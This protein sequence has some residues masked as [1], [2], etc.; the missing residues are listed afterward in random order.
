MTT[1]LKWL[2]K[3][4]LVCPSC[5]HGSSKIIDRKK[6]V[7]TLRRCDNCRLL[8]RTPTIT[9]EENHILYQE[10][11]QSDFTTDMPS[12]EE[13][14]SLKKAIFKDTVKDYSSRINVLEALSC[15]KGER[16][17]DFGCSWGY[18]SWQFSKAGYVVKAFEIS[19]P[20][21][22]YAKQY[23]GVEA[24]SSL[25]ELTGP[26]DIFFSSHVLGHVPNVRETI[27]DGWRKLRPG[28]LFV[29]FT[30]NSSNAYRMKHPN[31]WHD[32]WS[33]FLPNLLDEIYYN[34]VFEGFKKIIA[35]E[36]YPL[37]EFKQWA[38]TGKDYQTKE[39]SGAELL[40]VVRKAKQ[41]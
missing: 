21:C 29:A 12:L 38:L 39:L 26:F 32:S 18:G 10:E 28:G 16:L 4:G 30:P 14:E 34:Q 37:D 9:K 13:L 1:S 27:N 31:R 17:L 41:A 24:S 3:Q 36:P 35:S 11:Y 22:D 25:D 19:K 40:I 15:K 23:M 2:T 8:F 6:V 20:R 7:T 33:R 5:G